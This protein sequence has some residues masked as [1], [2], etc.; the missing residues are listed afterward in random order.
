MIKNI[1][2][3][4][5]G[6]LLQWKNS[7]EVVW[8]DD[9]TK[10]VRELKDYNLYY[11]TNILDKSGPHFDNLL[12]KELHYLGIEDGLASHHSQYRKPQPEFYQE[13]LNKC[14]LEANTCVFIDDK[15]PNIKAAKQIGMEG[16]INRP[17][18]TD[19]SLVL[20]QILGCDIG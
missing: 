6:V 5:E 7:K 13:F 12:V 20:T 17:N 8:Y 9:V 15:Y 2:F 14:K 19:L 16:V 18:I 11:L 1:V 10:L 4:L 3:D